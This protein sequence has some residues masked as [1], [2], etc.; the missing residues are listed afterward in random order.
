MNDSPG[1]TLNSPNTMSDRARGQLRMDLVAGQ[2]GQNSKLS[3]RELTTRY[4]IGA[5]PIREALH[6]LAGEGFITLHGQR[7]F[8]VPPMSL[9]DLED[10]IEVR[11]LIEEAAVRQTIANGGDK[12]EADVVSALHLVERHA[13]RYAGRCTNNSVAG[14]NRK[15]R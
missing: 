3:V 6:H 4:G 8:A 9:V 11:A 2:W 14:C 15:T 13:A 1:A 7:G 5:S 12:W 10:L